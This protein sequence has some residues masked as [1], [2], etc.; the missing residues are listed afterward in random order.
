MTVYYVSEEPDIRVFEP[1]L[2]SGGEPLVWAIDDEHLRNYLVPRECP[3]V[4][5][6]AGPDTSA[7]DRERFLGTST[8]VVAIESGWV[9]RIRSCRLF[10]YHLPADTFENIDTTAGY[11]VSRVAVEPLKIEVIDDPMSA[12]A[13]RGVELRV[14]SELWTLHDAVVESSL[15]FSIIR[16]RNAA[17]RRA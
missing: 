2:V 7:S 8:A 12:I 10:C 1:R 9:E 15:E 17:P 16:W 14:L 5:L 6:Y 3:R 4:T 13:H 11:L